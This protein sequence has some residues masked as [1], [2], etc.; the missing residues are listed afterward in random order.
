MKLLAIDPASYKLGLAL[1][2][3]GVLLGAQTVEAAANLDRLARMSYMIDKVAEVMTYF[4]P[5]T[6]V[7]EDPFLKGKGN[8]I[9]ERLKGCME[10]TTQIILGWPTERSITDMIHYIAPTTVK[11]YMGS[12]SLDKL[13]VATAAFSFIHT[14]DGKEL[15]A[16]L[17]ESKEWDATDAIAIGLSYYLKFKP[18]E[19]Q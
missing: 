6:I 18:Q 15:L 14:E 17:I 5:E 1:F 16:E 8:P 11:K 3:D 4:R 19:I 10:A 2:E 12:G 9:M 13:E 7:I